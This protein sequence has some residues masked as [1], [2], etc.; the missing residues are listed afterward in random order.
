[1]RRWLLAHRPRPALD[2]RALLVATAIG[3]LLVVPSS[4]AP[5]SFAAAT[6]EEAFGS[7]G[8]AFYRFPPHAGARATIVDLAAAG[9]RRMVGA[10]SNRAANSMRAYFGAARFNADGSLDRSFG[11]SGFAK[12]VR[13]RLGGAVGLVHGQAEAVTVDRQGRVVLAGFRFRDATS[14]VRYPVLVRLLPNGAPDR[15]FGRNGVVTPSHVPHDGEWF[16]D[17]IVEAGGRIVA[18]GGRTQLHEE[19]GYHGPKPATLV[20]AFLPDGRIDRSFADRGSLITPVSSDS[21]FRDF[22]ALRTVRVLRGGKLL[23]SGYRNYRL[24]LE[25]LTP[26]GQLDRSFGRGGS[27]Q[28]GFKGSECIY[29]CEYDSALMLARNNRILVQGVLNPLASEREALVRFLP[30]GRVDRSFGNRGFAYDRFGENLVDIGAVAPAPHD[31][32]LVVGSGHGRSSSRS[33]LLALRFAP[34]GSLDPG[35]GEHGM[36]PLGPQK[37][38]SDGETALARPDGSV[39]AGGGAWLP[40]NARESGRGSQVLMLA[41]LR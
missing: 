34:D 13:P 27:V 3:A 37:G 41:R 22:T 14:Q 12:L 36:L 15:S 18:V 38:N 23:L 8:L 17:V 32:F 26:D 2:A 1:M 25:R 10:L 7:D 20:R 19:D 24:L 28:V 40:G 21:Y 29:L 33:S 4:L 6:S 39:V 9:Q 16:S 30:D 5:L 31:R 35:F 11:Q